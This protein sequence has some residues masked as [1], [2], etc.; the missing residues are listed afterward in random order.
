MSNTDEKTPRKPRV[1]FDP[2]MPTYEYRDTGGLSLSV[3]RKRTVREALP[4]NILA[5]L[6]VG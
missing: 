6:K 4:T 2:K 3:D 5:H 1:V